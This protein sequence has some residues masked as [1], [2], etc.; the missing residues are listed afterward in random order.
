MVKVRKIKNPGYN[1]RK[2][3]FNQKANIDVTLVSC[4]KVK[5]ATCPSNYSDFHTLKSGVYSVRNA[6]EN[7]HIFLLRD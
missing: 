2:I 6:L 7:P 3:E 5:L 4:M 1:Y